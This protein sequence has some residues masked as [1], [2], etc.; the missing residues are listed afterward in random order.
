[1]VVKKRELSSLFFCLKRM[2][3][4]EKLI[5]KVEENTKGVVDI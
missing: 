4:T 5:Y 3:D 1:M 2:K